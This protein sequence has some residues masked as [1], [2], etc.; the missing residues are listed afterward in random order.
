MSP[1]VC[2]TKTPNVPWGAPGSAGGSELMLQG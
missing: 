2:V 1:L